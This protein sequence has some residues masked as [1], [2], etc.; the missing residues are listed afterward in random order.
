VTMGTKRRARPFRLWPALLIAGGLLGGCI[1]PFPEVS[2]TSMDGSVDRGLDMDS[3]RADMPRTID[4]TLDARAFDADVLPDMVGFDRGDLDAAPRPPDAMSPVDMGPLA[5]AAIV[6]AR[7]VPDLFVP[8]A[9]PPPECPLGDEWARAEGGFCV[10]IQQIQ[11]GPGWTGVWGHGAARLP[12]DSVVIAGGAAADGATRATWRFADDA[13]AEG[14]DLNRE[15]RS[16]ATHLRRD[17]QLFLF[18]GSR[19]GQRA[20]TGTRSDN[21]THRRNVA[22]GQWEENPPEKNPV[23]RSQAAAV[24]LRA[25][26]DRVVVAGGYVDSAVRADAQLFANDAWTATAAL[27][28][29][30][31]GA[32]MI[33]LPAP[34][35]R[36][37]A[38]GGVGAAGAVFAPEIID[39]AADESLW[40]GLDHGLMDAQHA[41]AA[42]A[43]T[44]DGQTYV[45]GGLNADGIASALF[46]V[47]SPDDMRWTRLPD[48]PS[49]VAH[50]T[51]TALPDGRLVVM[52]GHRLNAGMVR[53]RV[54]V[55]VPGEGWLISRTLMAARQDHTATLLDGGRIL[56][57]GGFDP[58]IGGPAATVEVHTIG[59]L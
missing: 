35:Q 53:S 58:Q 52:G 4:A 3:D 36:V 34:G 43:T 25:P 18:M 23:P 9:A 37:M 48:M 39:F 2:Q 19:D 7:P 54:S 33:T 40:L 56:V 16:F 6:D 49:A 14:S 55:Y 10:R 11:T 1:A 47:F 28:T 31:A 30:R 44:P 45:T 12:D 24:Q 42:S 51:L 38:F 13:I 46:L 27:T 21:R 20:D 26:D 57:V 5:D 8:D 29:A 15:K 59:A 32:H 41:H 22:N 50:H 17:G